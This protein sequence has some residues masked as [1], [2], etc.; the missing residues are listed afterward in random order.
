MI[1]SLPLAAR[2]VFASEV[3]NLLITEF[4][5]TM[6]LRFAPG[7]EYLELRVLP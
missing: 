1:S 7:D 2:E 4:V 6:V 5:E 3:R